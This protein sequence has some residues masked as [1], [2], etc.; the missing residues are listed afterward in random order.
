MYLYQYK[1]NKW[2]VVQHFQTMGDILV[3][4]NKTNNHYDISMS[5]KYRKELSIGEIEKLKLIKDQFN[6]GSNWVMDW[7]NFILHW[8][9]KYYCS[10]DFK[11][12]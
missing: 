4:N 3:L 9:K 12:C 2:R 8:N 7:K 1:N 6:K 5:F 10:E 11:S